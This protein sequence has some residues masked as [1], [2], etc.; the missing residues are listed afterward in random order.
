MRRH[1]TVPIEAARMSTTNMAFD[2][3]R[4]RKELGYA[5]R[6]A[7]QA[8]FDS[9]RWFVENGYVKGSR[10]ARIRWRIPS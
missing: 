10:R 7:Q 2:D 8:V 3:S 4:A 5:P 6:P 1:P 9:A